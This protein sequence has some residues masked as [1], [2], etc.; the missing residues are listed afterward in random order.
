[1]QLLKDR[2]KRDAQVLPG[3]VIKVSSFLNHMIDTTL[4]HEIAVEFARRFRQ[5]GVT[6]ILT[7]EASGIAFAV[8]VGVELNVPV[9]FAKKTAG[10]N[11][12]AD[13]VWSTG[14]RSYTKGTQC[15]I[16]VSRQYLSV[17][18]R[19]LIVDDFLAYGEAVT[20]L[21]ELVRMSG[22]S[23]VGAGIV[24]EKAYEPGGSKLREGGLRVES[25][26]RISSIEDGV[27]RFS[28]TV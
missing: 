25:L 21:A 16:H 24:I 9:V 7:I 8:L 20:G 22:G 3:G 12:A 4:A 13:S 6:K 28:E 10:S 1:M 11:T 27:I 15:T 2:I 23:L 19:V 17:E 5:S 14:V 26:A 18:D